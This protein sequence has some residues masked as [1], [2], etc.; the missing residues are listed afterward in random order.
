MGCLISIVV[1]VVTVTCPSRPTI[2][3]ASV[4]AQA[5]GLSNRTN[6]Y[7]PTLEDVRHRVVLVPAPAPATRSKVE[8][9]SDIARAIRMGI[10]GGY[11][12]LE[13]SILHSGGTK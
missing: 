6:V 8:R 3:A 7:T 10:P 2:D 13:W 11:T 5:P 4:L 12:I 9:E 1:A